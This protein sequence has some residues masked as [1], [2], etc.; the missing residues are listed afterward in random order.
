MRRMLLCRYRYRTHGHAKTSTYPPIQVRPA[1]PPAGTLKVTPRHRTY[2]TSSA[3]DPWPRRR[4]WTPPDTRPAH[5]KTCRHPCSAAVLVRRSPTVTATRARRCPALTTFP[6]VWSGVSRP[7]APPPT[8][9]VTQ[10]SHTCTP[11][12]PTRRHHLRP[13]AC[14]L[15]SESSWEKSSKSS[16]EGTNTS[17]FRQTTANFQQRTLFLFSFCFIM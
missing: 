14:F 2:R 7:G 17:F 3:P 1:Q 16:G 12:H 10:Q 8:R 9:S 11:I 5:S 6:A 13:A 15:L 4:C